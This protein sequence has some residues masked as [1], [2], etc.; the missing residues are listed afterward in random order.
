M[1][2]PNDVED[3]YLDKSNPYILM[4]GA[5]MKPFNTGIPDPL[6]PTGNNMMTQEYHLD[7]PVTGDRLFTRYGT[8]L[9]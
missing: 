9:Q 4:T 7:T 6:G 1:E 8:Y 3:R 5:T 2:L